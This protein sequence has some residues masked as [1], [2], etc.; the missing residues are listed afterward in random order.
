M[1]QTVKFLGLKNL[2]IA[3]NIVIV[4]ADFE[5]ISKGRRRMSATKELQSTNLEMQLDFF[6]EKARDFLI[7]KFMI[8]RDRA[9]ASL[10]T[11]GQEFALPTS[12]YPRSRLG[13]NTSFGQ[14]RRPEFSSGRKT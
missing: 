3:A 4:N 12:D 14:K 1:L 6:K 8:N 2:A 10:A 5:H 7:A 11:P 9:R 13:V